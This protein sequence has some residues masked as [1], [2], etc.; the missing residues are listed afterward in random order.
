MNKNID[1]KK[2]S[3]PLKKEQTKVKNEKAKTEK[4]VTKELNLKKKKKIKS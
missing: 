4:P 3:K 2:N 1:E